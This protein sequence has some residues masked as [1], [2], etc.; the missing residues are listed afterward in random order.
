MKAAEIR[1]IGSACVLTDR[2]FFHFLQKDNRPAGAACSGYSSPSDAM[3][4]QFCSW[5]GSRVSSA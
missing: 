5:D 4:M 3:R 2:A 1:M